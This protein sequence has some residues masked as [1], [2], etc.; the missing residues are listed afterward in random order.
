MG[1]CSAACMPV[2]SLL[3]SALVT[4]VTTESILI[5]CVIF[6][7]AVFAVLALA[8]PQMEIEE[9]SL[10]IKNEKLSANVG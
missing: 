10:G 4:Y 8:K 6:A 2:G 1:A 7:A 3:L 9:G 5:F